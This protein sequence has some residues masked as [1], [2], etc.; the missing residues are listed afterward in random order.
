MKTEFTDNLFRDTLQTKLEIK[1]LLALSSHL[2]CKAYRHWTHLTRLLKGS[3][4]K[5]SFD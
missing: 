1:I 5:K 3:K 4:F 2:T